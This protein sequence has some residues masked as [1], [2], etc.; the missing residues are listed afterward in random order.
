VLH[1]SLTLSQL[2]LSPASLFPDEPRAYV[3]GVP[4]KTRAQRKE[5]RPELTL[6]R[7]ELAAGQT[8]EVR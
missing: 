4:T 5:G 2:S 3:D 8:L 6:P 1:G 7:V